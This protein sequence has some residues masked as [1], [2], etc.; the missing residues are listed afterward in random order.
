[1][2]GIEW[3]DRGV[4]REV[5]QAVRVAC[6]EGA[7]KVAQDARRLVPKD[8]GDLRDSIKV[9]PSKFKDGGYLVVA[10]GS[11]DYD[12]FYATFVELG[13]YSSLWGLYSRKKKNIKTSP[14][15]IKKRPYLRPALRKNKRAIQRAF[16]DLIKG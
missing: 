4:L 13:H 1:V 16:D 14:I 12:R 9:E 7:E 2:I 5:R 6:K 8:D 10:Q 3:N 15:K 11:G